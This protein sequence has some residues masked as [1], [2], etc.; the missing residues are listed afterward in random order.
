[1]AIFVRDM[2]FIITYWNRGAEELY[3][4]TPEQAIGKSSDE[5]RG[6]AFPVPLENIRAGLLP[7]ERW[8][9]ELQ[10]TKADGVQVV[11][12]SRWSL[13]RNEREKPVAVLETSNDITD[14]KRRQEELNGST[15]NWPGALV[16]KAN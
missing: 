4:W 8:E 14:R 6:T 3:G 7:T 11:V 13:R 12:A 2:D 10:R 5:L 9:G 15:R 16:S 1:M